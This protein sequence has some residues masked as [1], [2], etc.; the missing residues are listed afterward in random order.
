MSIW[1][2]PRP[3]A[4]SPCSNANDLPDAPAPGEAAPAPLAPRSDAPSPGDAQ[5]LAKLVQD[6]QMLLFSNT[7]WAREQGLP[8]ISTF[9]QDL[10]D[11][12][13]AFVRHLGMGTFQ[14]EGDAF[15]GTFDGGHAM[16]RMPD[17]TAF[18]QF[19]LDKGKWDY[20]KAAV[21]AALAKLTTQ[22]PTELTGTTGPV[23]NVG[24]A[25]AYRDLQGQEHTG[26]VT[27]IQRS[28]LGTEHVAMD[29]GHK[30]ESTNPNLRKI[31]VSA[32]P[33]AWPGLGQTQ[34]TPAALDAANAKTASELIAQ[35]AK[36]G[37]TGIDEAFK[38]LSAIF[39]KPGL[40]RSFPGGIDEQSYQD[41]KPHFKAALAAFQAAGKTLV[42]LFQ[43][44]IEKYGAGVRPYA[45]R[46]AKE[47]ALT[48]QLGSQP[49]ATV[50]LA[51]QI[52]Q[53]L[54]SGQAFTWQTLFSYA[55][56]AYGGTQAQGTYT[57]KDAYDA[58][59][60]GINR[61]LMQSNGL[62]FNPQAT[63]EQA[64]L[65]VAALERLLELVPTQSKRTAE[66]NE[67]QQF[68]TV[69]PLA[70]LANWVANV[71]PNDTMLKRSDCSV[72]TTLL[73]LL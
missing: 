28:S 63:P 38:G 67:F 1:A 44:L 59:E 71:G 36:L 46:F 47:Q 66:T 64:Q 26:V 57:P 49:S 16:Q 58:M 5:M 32:A 37:V 70:Y 9:T 52:A 30:V 24:D 14:V 4:C 41:A 11:K 25:V 53:L 51:D 55:D 62:L 39:G 21:L 23:F 54:N 61:Y 22:A 56:K 35:A 40:L 15:S 18:T 17:G 68:S 27:G 6:G 8:S 3:T 33:S 31:A 34:P 65:T 73:V 7:A 50:V 10:K 42:E 43:M 29:T 19:A 48:A 2:R 69:P 72:H 60:A 12:G 45:K 20:P 13:E